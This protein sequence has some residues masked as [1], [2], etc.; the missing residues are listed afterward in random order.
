MH[1]TEVQPLGEWTQHWAE[2]RNALLNA[3]LAFY[4]YGLLVIAP[5]A[6]I[7]METTYG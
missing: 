5:H 6:N 7:E 4:I 1:P 2:A 3:N